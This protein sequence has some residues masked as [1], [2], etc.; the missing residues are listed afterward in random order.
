MA[1]QQKRLANQRQRDAAERLKATGDSWNR[2]HRIDGIFLTPCPPF[3]VHKNAA[4]GVA[5]IGLAGGPMAKRAA[6]IYVNAA[7]E[8][9][10]RDGRPTTLGAAIHRA[11]S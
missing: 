9:V 1:Q 5:Y 8:F 2:A 3:L 10:T 7:G 6:S 11:R 4:A